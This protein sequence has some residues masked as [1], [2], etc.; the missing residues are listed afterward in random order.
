MNTMS[1]KLSAI[2]AAHADAVK[3]FKGGGELS[4][5]LELAL[6]AYYY[7]QL[8]TKAQHDVDDDGE[9]E[10]LFAHDLGEDE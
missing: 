6:H 8:S 3:H 10:Q 4:E 7:N 9:L 2:I 5:E 1:S